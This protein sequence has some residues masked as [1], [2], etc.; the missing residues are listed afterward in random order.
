MTVVKD[1]TGTY[2]RYKE[3]DYHVCNLEMTSSYENGALVTATVK[4]IKE[5]KGSAMN[6]IVCAMIH[7]NEGWILIEKIK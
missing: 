3:K 5:C 6:E 1:C 2:L 4:K 7:D